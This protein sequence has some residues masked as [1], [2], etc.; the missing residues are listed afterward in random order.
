LQELLNT[1]NIQF[2]KHKPILGQPDIFIEPNICIFADGDY[3][4]GWNYL[5]GKD[6]SKYR[7]LNNE[8]FEKKIK[9]DQSVTTRLEAKGYKVLRLWEHEIYQEPKKCLNRIRALL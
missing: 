5:Q 1:N 6:Y 2:T 8:H 7:A 3:P 9:K 4:H